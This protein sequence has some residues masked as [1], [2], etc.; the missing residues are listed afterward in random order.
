M[1]F[2]FSRFTCSLLRLQPSTRMLLVS[3]ENFVG[4][5]CRRDSHSMK[6]QHIK[7][8]HKVAEACNV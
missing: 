8:A 5:K 1:D 2:R 4:E 3:S 6:D 7:M